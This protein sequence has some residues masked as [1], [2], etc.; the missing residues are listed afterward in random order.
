MKRFDRSISATQTMTQALNAAEIYASA[1]LFET[2]C[3]FS[4]SYIL[5]TFPT[6]PAETMTDVSDRQDSSARLGW[7]HQ[8]NSNPV[9]LA[10]QVN[11]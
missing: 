2:F 9:P 3:K 11:T 1:H 5:E 8:W 4:H 10:Y 7:P 6:L